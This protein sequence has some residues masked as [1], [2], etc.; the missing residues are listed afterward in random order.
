M[1]KKEF[2]VA[3]RTEADKR[4]KEYEELPAFLRNIPFSRLAL[5]DGLAELAAHN[6]PKIEPEES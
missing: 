5:A 1:T 4:I 2:I 3:F 6:A